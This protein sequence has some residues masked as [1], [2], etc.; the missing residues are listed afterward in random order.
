M[1]G[2]G[3]QSGGGAGALGWGGLAPAQQQTTQA[4]PQAVA[5]Y[6]QALNMANQ[7]IQSTPWQNYSTDPNAFVA[8]MTGTQQAAIGGLSGIA[9][10]GQ[11][12][13]QA[14]PAMQ[15]AAGM[16]PSSAVVGQYMN[17]FMQQVV[18]PV[19]QALQ[20]QQ[21]QQ[22]A[23]Q[24]AEAIRSGA[25]GG[26]NAATQRALLQ[27]QQNLA[28]GQALSPLYQTGYGQALGAA[29]TD[30]QRQLAAGQGLSQAGTQALQAQ[31]AG[32]TQQQQ[33]QQAGLSALYN[34]FLQSRQ[35]PYQQA[36][37]YAGI[38][39]GLGPLLGQQTYQA[40][41]TSPFGTFLASRGG[42]VDQSRMGGAVTS[43]GDF[44]RGGYATD[45]SVDDDLV[46]SQEQM[47]KDIEKPVD[48]SLPTGQ[49]QSAKGLDPVQFSPQQ[50]PESAVDKLTKLASL[51]KEAYGLGKGA[52]DVGKGVYDWT[53]GQNLAP[54]VGLNLFPSSWSAPA[55]A[56]VA[57]SV[58]ADAG[59]GGFL[60]G[61]G[62][63]ITDAL[64]FLALEKG[65]RVGLQDGGSGSS[66]DIFERGVLGAESS[67][68]QFDKQGRTLTSPKGALG[69]AQIMP[70]TAPE[71]AKLAGLKYDPERLRS[72][73]A[74][75]KALGRAYYNEQ[76]RKFG[77][78]EL[79]LAAYNAGPGRVQK[80][81]QQAG[82]GGD[83]MSLLPRETQAY[84]PK[85][86]GL[87][88]SDA[89]GAIRRARALDRG[90]MAKADLP[91]EGSTVDIGG[92]VK[93]SE[94]EGIGFNRQTIIP[95]LVGLGTAL[96]GMV[97]AKTT[98]PGAAIAS[99]LGQGLAGGAK[100]YME[101]GL[102]IPEIEKRKQE[103]L[104]EAQEVRAKEQLVGKMTYEKMLEEQK[105][106]QSAFFERAGIPMVRLAD[107][108]EISQFEWM[109]HPTP[110]WSGGA[111]APGAPTPTSTQP[112]A[113]RPIGVGD[114]TAEAPPG[115]GFDP[116]SKQ[117][118]TNELQVTMGPGKPAAEARSAAYR[119]D[120]D[121]NAEVAYG[122]KLYN[123]DV[124]GI[125]SDA[126]QKT[127]IG[128]PGAGASTRAVIVNYVNTIARAAGMGD[129]YMGSGIDSNAA[130][131][132]KINTLA[133]QGRV[134]EANQTALGSLAK[135]VNAQPNLD[136]P[137][138]ASTFNA[139]SNM[140]NNQMK[141]DQQLHADAYGQHSGGLY[142][143][144]AIDFKRLNTP[145]KY[146]KEQDALQAVMVKDPE[147]FSAMVSGKLDPAHIEQYFKDKTHGG[148][149]G[150]SR[151]FES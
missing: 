66:D 149:T 2:K 13:Y 76:L 78:D 31:L 102:Q 75:N 80:A 4:S 42:S 53:K 65:G 6:T 101:T 22:L 135:L 24:Q 12:Y 40:Q 88:G 90:Y 8:P 141:L 16:T 39:G 131:L 84:V 81:I 38:A 110:V 71:A 3:S 99:G 139:A 45:G 91:E 112:T 134:S 15:A 138:Q 48:P 34:Q 59:G 150:M 79:A 119:A 82:P 47:Y 104:R 140:V 26:S 36:Q 122:Q 151:Y 89:E 44:S 25:F 129:N 55:A 73:E 56:D 115:I 50:K 93:P 7:A 147:A 41:A 117:I 98:S 120:V 125:L 142:S 95:A 109:K 94:E 126:I 19:Q 86:L 114:T 28:M 1:C 52:Y 105:L 74:Y 35:Y 133:G 9:G 107:G 43:A 121:K 130:I 30:L 83:V 32:G 128:A 70:E 96:S 68:H 63:A 10:A 144:A 67:N 123:N 21:G 51:G 18:S 143:R 64:P 85:A 113:Q 49:I 61:L 60:A 27:G 87:A 146:R 23:Q 11:P 127:G 137:P 103:A 92:G 106:H 124:A 116:R 57:G 148:L 72:D 33:T 111:G 145:G 108:S 54:A 58:A 132:D 77:T 14:A 29:Q 5:A 17:P 136:Q 69:I 46:K 100:T 37:F 20:Q 97:G 118:A 62:T